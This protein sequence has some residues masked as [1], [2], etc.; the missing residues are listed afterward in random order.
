MNF[1]FC[2]HIPVDTID[3]NK[4]PITISRKVAVGVARDS[5]KL[6]WHP[7]N[8]IIIIIIIYL[9]SKHIRN[10]SCSKKSFHEQDVPGSYRAHRAVIIAIARLS[11]PVYV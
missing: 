8:Y 4:S 6:S 2:T 1:K 3:R 5:R 9:L 7:Y 10:D 11:C